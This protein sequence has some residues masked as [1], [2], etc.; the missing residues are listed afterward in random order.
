MMP[1]QAFNNKSSC[2][3]FCCCRRQF[4]LLCSVAFQAQA[5]AS[6]ALTANLLTFP[7]QLYTSFIDLSRL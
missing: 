3:A 5:L 2:A 1:K 7:A 6:L 4:D